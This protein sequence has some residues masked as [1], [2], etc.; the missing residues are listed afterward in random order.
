MRLTPLG[1]L[2]VALVVAAGVLVWA[3]H[4]TDPTS[5]S[6]TDPAQPPAMLP[7][8]V[9]ACG[10]RIRRPGPRCFQYPDSLAAWDGSV[11]GDC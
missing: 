11:V 7:L 3:A 1:W 4:A 10:A 9:D 8:P 2:V 5:V 6:W